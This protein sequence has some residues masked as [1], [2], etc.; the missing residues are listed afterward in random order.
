[1]GCRQFVPRVLELTGSS[2]N[3]ETVYHLV[4]GVV[5]AAPAPSLR[6]RVESAFVGP[7]VQFSLP[8]LPPVLE[9]PSGPLFS[10]SL[11]VCAARNIRV[12]WLCVFA[13]FF[14]FVLRLEFTML[15][16]LVWNS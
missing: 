2:Q 4:R 5:I 9:F 3:S 13:F 8:G 11:E 15:L 6:L 1:M 12:S 10:Y 14:V 7:S 16:R